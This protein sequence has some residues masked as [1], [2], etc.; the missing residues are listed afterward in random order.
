MKKMKFSLMF[1]VIVIG[2]FAVS[3]QLVTTQASS[4]STHTTGHRH[5]N[6]DSNSTDSGSHDGGSNSTSDGEHDA[7]HNGVTDSM[8]QAYQ[9]D[10]QVEN[11]AHSF[12]AS[13]KLQNGSSQDEFQVE[14][15]TESG[16]GAQMEFQYHSEVQNANSSTSTELSYK[17]KLDKVIEFVDTGAVGYQNETILQTYQIG[18][19]GWNN[20]I[21]NQN[22]TSGVVSIN[23]TTADG[24]FTL[25]LKLSGAFTKDHNVTLS[26]TSMKIDVLFNNFNY[27]TTGSKLAMSSYVKTGDNLKEQHQSEDERQ[28]IASNET[29]L[30]IDNTASNTTGYFSWADYATADGQQVPVVPSNLINAT[31]EEGEAASKMYFTFNTTMQMQHMLWDPKMGVISQA[32]E[33][34]LAAIVQA[35][36]SSTPAANTPTTSTQQPV[37]TP[38]EQTTEAKSMPISLFWG[39]FFLVAVPVIRRVRN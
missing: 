18:Q 12:Q 26:P 2:F 25:M 16:S 36:T 35:S 19:S 9:R 8:D 23:A 21:V 10:L 5:I 34:N 15:N 30:G 1:L 28:G 3:G 6:D 37:A 11:D 17:I 7:N 27:T 24:V 4:G 29:Q 38:Q 20:I 13:S 31:G 14:F 39:L 33:Q 22:A 32:S